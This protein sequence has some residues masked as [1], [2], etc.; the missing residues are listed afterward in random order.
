M[1][2]FSYDMVCNR[3]HHGR[4][5][6]GIVGYHEAEEITVAG[7][8]NVIQGCGGRSECKNPPT[9]ELHPCPYSE[10]IHD[11][12]SDKCNCCEMCQQECADDI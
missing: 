3:H 9:E 12:S 8:L 5:V 6:V 11:D 2:Q 10:E 1:I 4:I 7:K